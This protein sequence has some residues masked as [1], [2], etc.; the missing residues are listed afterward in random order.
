MYVTG[1]GRKEKRE[2]MAYG[3]VDGGNEKRQS[4]V[5]AITE[6]RRDRTWY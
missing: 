6:K 1:D 5:P 4:V 2:K 3:T